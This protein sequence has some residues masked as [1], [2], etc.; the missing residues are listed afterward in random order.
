[1]KMKKRRSYLPQLPSC[2]RACSDQLSVG[3]PP[4]GH[5]GSRE[6][7]RLFQGQSIYLSC[8]YI[9]PV[10]T[11]R[12]CCQDRRTSARACLQYILTFFLLQ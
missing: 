12:T 6:G 11:K 1:M 5:F 8:L 7:T 4:L 3:N 10:T 2:Y 9:A